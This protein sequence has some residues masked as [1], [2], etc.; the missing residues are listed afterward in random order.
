MVGV[1]FHYGRKTGLCGWSDDRQMH[2]FHDAVMVQL[3]LFSPFVVEPTQVGGGE[4]GRDDGDAVMD[5]LY[6][7]DCAMDDRE[8]AVFCREVLPTYLSPIRKSLL[9]EQWIGI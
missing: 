5:H 3:D 2:A 6:G 4:G 8:W 1:G 7:H 9:T